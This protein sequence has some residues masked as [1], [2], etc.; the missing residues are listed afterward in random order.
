MYK[1]VL[2]NIQSIHHIRWINKINK[3]HEIIHPITF[4]LFPKPHIGQSDVCDFVVGKS[5]VG[6]RC[7][8]KIPSHFQWVFRFQIPILFTFFL[9]PIERGFH[10]NTQFIMINK[11]HQTLH[12][13]ITMVTVHFFNQSN[14]H[15]NKDTKG[16]SVHLK[17]HI[18]YN[19]SCNL[20]Y[21]AIKT[22]TMA[23]VTMTT[24]TMTN[25][26]VVFMLLW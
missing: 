22:A 18:L 4:H 19:S 20:Q 17:Q 14:Y 7:H 21:K 12:R 10:G 16:L 9:Q 8:H 13:L 3:L 1:Y 11:I 5:P 6:N 24:V 26:D 23:T 2:M 15:G 25:S